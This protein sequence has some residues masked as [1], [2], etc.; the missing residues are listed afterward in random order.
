MLRLGQV[1][2]STQGGL[3]LTF[4]GEYYAMFRDFM[5]VRVSQP[6][7]DAIFFV[8][9]QAKSLDLELTLFYHC[10]NKKKDIPKFGP[11]SFYGAKILSFEK[12]PG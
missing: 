8:K 2:A 10:H 11:V 9:L 3:F 6:S 7:T 1:L 4:L 12:F 5:K